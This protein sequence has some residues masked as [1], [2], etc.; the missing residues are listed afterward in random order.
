M[1]IQHTSFKTAVSLTIFSIID[2]IKVTSSASY[3]D[4]LEV[5]FNNSILALTDDISPFDNDYRN[6]RDFSFLKP[7]GLLA[8]SGNL[9][10]I[11]VYLFSHLSLH[12]S[13]NQSINQSI[14]RSIDQSISQC[15]Q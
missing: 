3:S 14:D 6:A 1:E 4:I 9:V 11:N 15:Y 13:I 10:N 2:T 7:S 8:L 5:K 12:S